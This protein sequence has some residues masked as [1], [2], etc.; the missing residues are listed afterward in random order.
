LPARNG[1]FNL[2]YTVH[3][4]L[5]SYVV[6]SDKGAVKDDFRR[7]GYRRERIRQ[8][9]QERFRIPIELLDPAG[10]EDAGR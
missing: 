9:L 6:E 2:Y 1:L 5:E 3:G 8:E 7:S 10:E 4:P